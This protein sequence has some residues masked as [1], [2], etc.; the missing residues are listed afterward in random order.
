MDPKLTTPS[1]SKSIAT[2]HGSSTKKIVLVDDHPITRAGLAAV[3]N[4]ATDLKVCGESDSTESGL[5][6]IQELQPDVAIVDISLKLENGLELVKKL[7]SQVPDL[8]VLVVSLHEEGIYAERA[9]RAGARGYVMK[10]E[11]GTSIVNAVRTVLKKELFLSEKMRA[12]MLHRLVNKKAKDDTSYSME[13]LS[14]RE[15]QVFILLGNG[16]STRLVAE[17]LELSVKTVDSYREH[18]KVKLNLGSSEEL[19]F[20]AIQWVKSEHVLAN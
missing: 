17:K 19:I 11:L 15:M 8:P 14:E 18:L 12:K 9:L 6:M 5:K 3:L 2:D 16:F 1:T 10:Q 20:Q 7:Q 13:T 4:Q